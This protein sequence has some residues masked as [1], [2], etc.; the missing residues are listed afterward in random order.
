MP[1]DIAK[2]EPP[3]KRLLAAISLLLCTAT[4]AQL[5]IL[6]ST[7][8]DWC[9]SNARDSSAQT[10]MKA[11][12]ARK[13]TGEVFAQLKAESANPNVDLWYGG[14]HDPHLQAANVGLLQLYVSA[15]MKDQ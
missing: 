12:L 4:Q 14:T 9:E 2:P 3:S 8:A 11:N 6:C 1:P 7:D 13:A 5:D 15:N 10:G